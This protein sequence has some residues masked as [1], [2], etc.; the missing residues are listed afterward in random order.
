M[1]AMMELPKLSRY[2]GYHGTIQQVWYWN[3]SRLPRITASPGID[4]GSTNSG[5]KMRMNERIPY[6]SPHYV[7]IPLVKPSVHFL[8]VAS[9]C[10]GP[11]R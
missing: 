9:V 11:D 8:F 7:T 2:I 1:E 5:F 6:L 4:S 10:L 3:W